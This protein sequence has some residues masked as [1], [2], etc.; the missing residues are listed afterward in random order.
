MHWVSWNTFQTWDG[1]ARIK[2]QDDQKDKRAAIMLPFYSLRKTRLRDRRCCQIGSDIEVLHLGAEH[3]RLRSAIR[4]N[5]VDVTDRQLFEPGFLLHREPQGP[6]CHICLRRG[7]NVPIALGRIRIHDLLVPTTSDQ[8]ARVRTVLLL[9][10]PCL[11]DIY[12]QLSAYTVGIVV[13]AITIEVAPVAGGTVI[14]QQLSPCDANDTRL[15]SNTS[16]RLLLNR[17]SLIRPCRA[18][19]NLLHDAGQT[20]FTTRR[21]RPPGSSAGCRCVARTTD[22]YTAC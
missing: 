16:I 5:Q 11:I 7:S 22:T 4:V 15:P 21:P 1:S 17:L 9:R 8:T 14:D 6:V 18:G 3:S 12:G 2:Q 20:F 10:Y 13:N 19:Q